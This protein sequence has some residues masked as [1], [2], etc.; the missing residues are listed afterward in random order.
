MT[1]FLK[2]IVPAPVL[3]QFTRIVLDV[4]SRYRLLPALP[5][6]SPPILFC[7]I[8]DIH[9]LKPARPD[10]QSGPAP[11]ASSQPALWS[12]PYAFHPPTPGRQL[13]PQTL[14]P[15]A[16]RRS[17]PRCVPPAP[18]PRISRAGANIRIASRPPTTPNAHAP[19]Q[20]LL[21]EPS[22]RP[23]PMYDSLSSDPRLTN[24]APSPSAP[25]SP[26]AKRKKP[27]LFTRLRKMLRRLTSTHLSSCA[28]Y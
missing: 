12:D 11:L 16:F 5:L 13:T 9:G 20:A 4:I 14:P 6:F 27:A 23:Q 2:R 24:S 26:V 28:H 3:E 18:A 8:I 17:Q 10:Y 22:P 25:R 7:S 21:P 15:Q 1:G 19:F